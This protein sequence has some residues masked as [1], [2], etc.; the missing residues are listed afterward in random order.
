MAPG[1]RIRRAAALVVLAA[2]VLTGAG[3]AAAAPPSRGLWV[4]RAAFAV[5]LAQ[6]EHL[7]RGLVGPRFRDVPAGAAWAS[8]VE[9]VTGTDWM[10]GAGP[11]RFAP[12]APVT[13]L[14]AAVAAADAL[15]LRFV[16]RAATAWP[17]PFADA[18]AIPPG[19]RG[20]VA[21]A[22]DLGL[23]P[24]AR[25]RF[26][27]Q[28]PLQAAQAATLFRR[29]RGVRRSAVR[30]LGDRVAASVS[31]VPGS[32]ELPPHGLM[33]ITAYVHDATGYIVPAAVR[34]QVQGARI[35]AV[36]LGGRSTTLWVR[37]GGPGTATV[38]AWVPGTAVRGRVALA[39]QQAAALTLAPLPPAVLASVSLPLTVRVLTAA[40]QP[41]AAA[42][43]V[44]VIAQ[45]LPQGGG[46][47]PSVR[48]Q[49]DAGEATLQLPPLPPGRYRL[50]VASPG[51]GLRPVTAQLRS[52]SA[53][54]GRIRLQTATGGG[55]VAGKTMVVTAA[56]YGLAGSE[57]TAPW[58]IAVSVSGVQD[59][60]P[61]LRGE[62]PP[63]A[64]LVLAVASAHL[65]AAGGSVAVVDAAA[66]GTGT[67]AVAA[68]GGALRPASLTV[69]V[70][71]LGSLTGA[72]SAAVVVG[73]AATLG[74]RL[75]GP[76]AA[77]AGP[78][79]LEP[80]DPAGNPLPPIEATVVDGT[81][82]ARF[83]PLVAGTWTFRWR[84][85]GMLPLQAGQLR[86]RPG[87]PVRLVVDASPTSVLLPGQRVALQA[88]LA[89]RYGN[90]VPVP[91]T[92]TGGH[93]VG[94]NPRGSTGPPPPPGPPSL[95]PGGPAAP[96]PGPAGW[97]A[98][99]PSRFVGPG[100]VG[101][102]V[103]KAGPLGAQGLRETLA[104]HSPSDPAAGV[105]ELTLRV[106]AAPADRVAGKGLWLTFGDWHHTPDAAIVRQA[107]QLGATHIY[108]EVATSDDGFYG[109]RALDNFL[110]VAHAA[111][112]AVISWVYAGLQRPA[113]DAHILRQVATY[114]TPT[115]DRADGLALDL[116]G[117][118]TPE[119]VARY[120]RLARAL[121]GPRGLVVAVTD[122]PQYRPT[123]PFRALAPYVQV[124]A[125]M[126]YWHVV[127]RYYTYAQVYAWVRASVAQVRRRAGRPHA[128]VQVI[129]QTYDAFA[130]SGTGIFSPWPH[131]V[132]AADRAAVAAG[133]LGISYYRAATAT[134]AETTVIAAFRWPDP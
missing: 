63:P 97:L 3:R 35:A 73:H 16:A 79:F 29:L 10:D 18:Q 59:T 113:A 77:Q 120:A 86:A 91:F 22:V 123:Y 44:P 20:D 37:A 34:W 134:A 130:P 119:T 13:R 133:A 52:V 30:A 43:G 98:F 27:P 96:L 110:P 70:H 67:V 111:G 56:V 105:A 75:V 49:F 25:G 85:A 129:A 82:T 76:P 71:P 42:S 62:A 31:L 4:T 12:E 112:L 127:E 38:A 40:G 2:T 57:T 23:M 68:V 8:A 58:P 66:P 99:T 102:F 89:D 64:T 7:P 45:V 50:R 74:V 21:V 61:P 1:P 46:R 101:T 126:D 51:S 5:E 121:A 53:P 28:A 107:R 69:A 11:G 88:W 131:E 83:T 15:G 106:V 65:S 81:A 47:A 80:I 116:E 72:S 60:L 103:A 104:F 9:A 32:W 92:L 33:P 117:V 78:V 124:F 125:P 132:R 19:R 93:L 17:L 41:D 36:Q 109:G 114:V 95:V 115:G 122:P 128:P 90:P 48:G 6:V 84:A 24:F 14:V 55:L 26:A 100:V 108:L 94:A 39:V 54:M 118:L 87:P